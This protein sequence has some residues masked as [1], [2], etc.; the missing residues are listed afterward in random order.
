[1]DNFDAIETAYQNE[2]AASRMLRD[3]IREANT[4]PVATV[5]QITATKRGSCH[6]DQYQV[7][8]W[9]EQR[10]VMTARGMVIEATH[11][12]ITEA[13]MYRD[14]LLAK[15]IFAEVNP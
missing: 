8:S 4:L 1:M 3:R 12:T 14:V 10:N 6:W 2:E 7:L 15:D 11:L 13:K 9:E 5:E